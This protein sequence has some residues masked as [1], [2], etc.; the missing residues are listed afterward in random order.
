[1]DPDADT[2]AMGREIDQNLYAPHGLMPGEIAIVE[3]T[4]S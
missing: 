1:M 3:G 4:A 2:S